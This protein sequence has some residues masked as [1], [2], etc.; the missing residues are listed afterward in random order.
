M[1]PQDDAVEVYAG[2]S[3]QAGQIQEL[4]ENAGILAFLKDEQMGWLEAPALS[5]AGLDA[6]KVVVSRTDLQRAEQVVRDFGGQAGLRDEGP[7]PTIEMAMAPWK[8]SRCQE[9]VEGQFEVCWN[10]GAAKERE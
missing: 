8:C 1:D 6:V 7:A 2:A 4:L 10:C 3:W 5:A 9:H